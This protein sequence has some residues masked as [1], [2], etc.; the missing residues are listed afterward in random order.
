MAFPDLSPPPP[1]SPPCFSD[2]LALGAC[3]HGVGVGLTLG[4]KAI[5][6]I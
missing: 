1:T 2:A 3:G 6:A 4:L 5:G